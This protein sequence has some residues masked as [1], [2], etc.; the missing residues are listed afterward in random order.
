MMVNAIVASGMAGY[1]TLMRMGCPVRRV[2]MRKERADHNQRKQNDW[3][4]LRTVTDE[5]RLGD[6][7]RT[8]LAGDASRQTAAAVSLA[9][10]AQNVKAARK[11][12]YGVT[13]V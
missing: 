8:R 11:Q 2:K 4:F 5:R 1:A 10:L 13:G 6:H 9:Q 3:C 12:T 7:Y